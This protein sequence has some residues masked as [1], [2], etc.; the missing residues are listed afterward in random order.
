MTAADVSYVLSSLFGAWV[1]GYCVGHMFLKFRQ[2]IETS[3]GG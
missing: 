3:I 2:F 1:L